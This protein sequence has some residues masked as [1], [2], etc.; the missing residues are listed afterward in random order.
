MAACAGTLTS[1]AQV[2]LVEN[3]K[4]K[5]RIVVTTTEKADST[6]AVLLQDFVNR[7][8]QTKLPI[9]SVAQLDRRLY[10]N[11]IFIGNGLSNKALVT[12]QLTEDG[13]L[14][15]TED[16]H[17]RIIN[18]GDKGSIYGVVTL[19]EKYCG[20][21]YWGE[22]EY[23]LT[24]SKDLNL[25]KIHLAENPGFRYRQS[26]FYGMRDDADPIYRLWMRLD[27]P[28][29]YF[30]AGYWV[31]TFNRLLP[32]AV[33]GKDHPEYYAYFNGKRHPGTASQWCL[34]NPEILDI[35]AARV[36]SIF[37]ANPGCN[38]ISI[39]QNDSQ[40][41]CQ[42][43]K[44]KAINEREGAPSGSIIYFLNKLAERF[45]D[46]EFSTL[47]YLYSMNPPKYIK[48]LPNVNIMLCDIDCCRE[49]TLTENASGQA[50]MKAMKGWSEKTN[51]IFVWDYGINF[52]NYLV[53]FPNFHIMAEN[54]RL[55]KEHHTQMHF[56]Q[57]AGS[58]GG[59]FAEMRTW[60]AAKLM[61]N[62]EADM[63]ELLQTFIKGYY[64]EAAPFI[65]R[66]VKMIEG[67]LMGSG[68]RLWIYDSP[69]S[70]KYGMLKTVLMNRYKDLFDQAE[71]AVKND[72][73]LLARVQRT[74]LPLQYSELEIE[75]TNPEKNF[76]DLTKKLD[77]FEQQVK[78]FNVPTLNERSNSPVEYCQLY[79]QRYMPRQEK[80]LAAGAQIS[81]IQAPHARYAEMAKKS[82]TDELF[83]G[84][85]FTESWVGWEGTD[86]SFVVDLGEEKEISSVET[87]FLHQLGQWILLPREVSYATSTD[88]EHFTPAGKYPMAEDSD[89]K[90]KFVG[91]KHTFDNKIKT[92]YIRVDVVGTKICPP[93]HYGV[94]N[95]C[96]FF[97]DEVT[98]L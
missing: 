95:P 94:G 58:R 93:W 20:V 32:A 30:A 74:R 63:E 56:S 64:G 48:P 69:V 92:R 87:D 18:G 57:I 80:N 73:T 81:Y 67:A 25:P 75:R 44:C 16:G 85:S 53:P 89:Y 96:W 66:Y 52:D 97:I 11:D 6:A 72:S 61:W 46:K 21:N 7:I 62:P 43:D 54:I 9:V 1:Q 50:F 59:D 4:S 84:Q 86:G 22:K 78:R 38:T 19:L 47:A 3:G 77:Y 70:H 88:G 37:K 12:D 90:V 41:Y 76:E 98:V 39:S 82:L 8:T 55:F 60:L 49:V 5:A 91:I 2:G 26:Q 36:D 23:S 34:T 31:H 17:L 65:Y 68:Q 13:F 40:S 79:R 24:P 10:K 83:G 71:E 35:V 42:C 15:T 14:I 45:P 51:N 33:Y 27:E 28:K 29:D